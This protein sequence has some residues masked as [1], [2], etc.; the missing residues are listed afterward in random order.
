MHQKSLSS[1][2]NHSSKLWCVNSALREN[3]EEYV[4]CLAER[5]FCLFTSCTFRA[6]PSQ[7]C[8]V[9]LVP[10]DWAMGFGRQ[11]I[12]LLWKNYTLK[13][14]APV[15]GRSFATVLKHC[16]RPIWHNGLIFRNLSS[17][18]N[19]FPRDVGLNN[20]IFVCTKSW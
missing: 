1:G 5:F 20:I 14:R 17:F 15:S 16:S 13:K 9:R 11:L 10:I 7:S 19:S 2:L 18:V 6:K 8:G 12:L 4:S 3:F